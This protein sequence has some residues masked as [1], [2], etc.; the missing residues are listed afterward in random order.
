MCYLKQA[1]EGVYAFYHVF[2]TFLHQ[3]AEGRV[4]ALEKKLAKRK[5]E[6]QPFGNIL[7]QTIQSL[8]ADEVGFVWIT[9]TT[10]F[11]SS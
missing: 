2:N 5:A 7:K 4:Y 9:H 8:V 11:V 1:L 10:L 3:G 6:N